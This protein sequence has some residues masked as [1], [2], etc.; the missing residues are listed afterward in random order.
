M[1]RWTLLFGIF[2]TGIAL[3]SSAP[4]FA[5]GFVINPT[6]TAGFNSN[7]GANAPAAQAAW[8]AAANVFT[9]NFSDNITVNITVNAVAGTSVFGQSSTFLN[10]FSYAGLHNSVVADAKTPDDHTATGAGGSVS[11]TDPTGGAGTFWVSRAEAKALGL[12]ASDLSND[13]TTTFGAGNLFTFAGPVAAGTYDFQGVAAH[14]IS[15]VLGRLGIS[16]GTIGSFANSYSLIDLFSYT[17]AG[18]RALGAG[19]GE[20]FSIDNGSNLLKL[21]NNAAANGLDTR[22]WAPGTNDSFN[23]FSNSGVTNPVSD[24]DLREM[25]VIGY[26]RGVAQTPEPS[27]FLLLI[28]GLVAGGQ[29]RRRK[30]S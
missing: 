16:G 10:S 15:E 11:A 8:I 6:F 4:A 18:A 3:V 12:I 13:G 17:G 9:S 25:D 28:S 19:P 27:T 1:K 20:N 23:Q 29:V 30:R 22:D 26:D 7:F 2:L 5:D 24:V 14:E 21:Y